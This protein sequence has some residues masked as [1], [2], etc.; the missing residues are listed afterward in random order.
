M[1]TYKKY[2]TTTMFSGEICFSGESYDTYEEAK[3]HTTKVYPDVDWIECDKHGF[4]IDT[5]YDGKPC[6]WI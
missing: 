4:I 1:K 6:P 2:Y 5:S 3:A